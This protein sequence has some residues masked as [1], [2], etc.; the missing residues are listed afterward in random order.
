MLNTAAMVN[1]AEL[2]WRGA[3]EH[4]DRPCIT[5]LD[6]LDQPGRRSYQ[7]VRLRV[8]ALAGG[9]A[10]NGVTTGDRVAMLMRNSAQYIEVFLAL[11]TLGAVAVPLNVR[12]READF[13]HMLTDSGSRSLIAD[14]EFLASIPSLTEIADLRV[15]TSD[16]TGEGSLEDLASRGSPVE[17]PVR[18]DVESLMSLMY[19][20][21]TTGAPKAVMLSHRSWL[22]VSDAAR[23]TL[24]YEDGESVL[25]VAPLTHGAGFLLLPTLAVGG[26]N[27][28]VRTFDA[29][30][31]L[32]L[33]SSHGITGM[34]MVP[35]MI[36]MLLDAMPVGWEVPPTFRWLYYAGSPIHPE[37]LRAAAAALDSRMVQSFAQ[38]ESPML[39]TALG[40]EDHRLALR[41]PA[42]DVVRSAGRPLPGVELVIVG[43][44]GEPMPD[45]ESGEA[46]FR[47]PQTMLGYWGR[48]EATA[49]VLVDGMLHTGDVGYVGPNGYLYI[50]DRLKDMIVTGGSNVYAREVEEFLIGLPGVRDAAVIGL[51]D[52]LWGEAVTAV[53]VKD[54][55]GC[56]ASEVIKACRAALADYRV[57]K[58]VLWVDELPR[59][60][61]GKIMKRELRNAYTDSQ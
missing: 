27:L 38:M 43:E 41:D 17:V 34:F 22:A 59:N 15:W 42:S 1:I 20:S 14:S 8:A 26:N 48:P 21:G 24:D 60:A 50:V 33:M 57:P 30:R 6:T 3:D 5:D 49:A 54:G 56:E 10:A 61:Y 2:L 18:S 51:P 35:S 32:L 25:H 31:T 44:G 36:R 19:T 11:A 46:I 40:P 37:T 7:D 58:R 16:L 23:S 53:L 9:L 4:P 13:Q 12:L 28:L 52:R 45:G 55:P 39:L 47:A 29:R